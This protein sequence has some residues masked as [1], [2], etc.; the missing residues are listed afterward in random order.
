MKLE[1]GK[2]YRRRDGSGPVEIV[3][4][5]GYTYNYR[6]RTLGNIGYMSDGTYY[7]G[8]KTDFDLV[9]EWE[10]K[11]HAK[12]VD[13]WVET[14]P[15]PSDEEL[16]G[17]PYDT[18]D[19]PL[20][21]VNEE[22]KVKLSIPVIKYQAVYVECLPNGGVVISSGRSLIHEA[23]TKLAAFSTVEEAAAFIAKHLDNEGK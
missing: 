6:Y 17:K 3:K 18:Q 13:E 23:S 15:V 12:I 20:P 2:K 5:L 1:V 22:I 7:I 19:E 4:D 11:S 9:A 21:S 8:Q 16:D 14:L 10:T